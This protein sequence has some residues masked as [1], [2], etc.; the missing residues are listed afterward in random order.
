MTNTLLVIYPRVIIVLVMEAATRIATQ[1]PQVQVILQAK[2]PHK[3]NH[4]LGMHPYKPKN[5][6]DRAS[7]KQRSM[8]KELKK[9]N[10]RS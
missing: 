4:L 9:N 1:V 2:Q 7:Q 3:R 5:L 10:S 6:L 8:N